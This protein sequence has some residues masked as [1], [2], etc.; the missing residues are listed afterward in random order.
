[1]RVADSVAGSSAGEGSS[2]ATTKT[3]ANTAQRGG[4]ASNVAVPVPRQQAGEKEQEKAQQRRTATIEL[5]F[6]TAEFRVPDLHLPSMPSIPVEAIRSDV[7]R[8]VSEIR[9][10]L[11]SPEQTVYFAALGV[12][13]AVELIE[14]P[15][16]L[17]IGVGVA[18]VQRRSGGARRTARPPDVTVSAA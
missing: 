5:P 6:V 17:A 16:V 10:L 11:P 13:G 4:P 3:A 9:A 8:G 15:V 1:M 2:M 14:W 18:L 12:L 7:S